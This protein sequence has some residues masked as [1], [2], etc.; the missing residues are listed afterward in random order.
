[1]PAHAVDM[2]RCLLLNGTPCQV[3]NN[4]DLAAELSRRAD[5]QTEVVTKEMD[6]QSAHVVM[7]QHT[8]PLDPSREDVG[9]ITVSQNTANIGTVETANTV[10]LNIFGCSKRSIIGKDLSMIIPRPFA[11]MH[12]RYLHNF[13]ETGQ[14]VRR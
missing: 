8:G 12:N 6:D 2:R 1:M 3:A 9:V 10:A 5:E 14:T 11:S 4:P 13:L 7:F